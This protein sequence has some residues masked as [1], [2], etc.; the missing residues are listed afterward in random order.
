MSSTSR[1]LEQRIKLI[2]NVGVGGRVR[3][4]SHRTREEN[5]ER[6]DR[7]GVGIGDHK[8]DD[9]ND[10]F[11]NVWKEQLTTERSKDWAR[12]PVDTAHCYEETCIFPLL[13]TDYGPR[14]G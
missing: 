11:C 12:V 5:R 2:F 8:R 9:Y 7:E 1:A 3:R 10:R 6:R 4:Q 13:W 14:L